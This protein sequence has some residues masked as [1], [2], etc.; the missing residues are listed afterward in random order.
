MLASGPSTRGGASGAG[1]VGAPRG[2]KA[3]PNARNG[4]STAATAAA[5]VP[6]TP[7]EEAKRKE[8]EKALEAEARKRT[9]TD[10]RII[11]LEIKAFD[12]S[13]GQIK[14]GLDADDFEEQ[15]QLLNDDEEDEEE[16]ELK[17]KRRRER[18]EEDVAVE[19]V[20]VENAEVA[21]KPE[22]TA[23]VDSFEVFDV[24]AGESVKAEEAEPKQD[25]ADAPSAEQKETVTEEEAKKEDAAVAKVDE[26]EE[27]RGA[28]R[29]AK[30]SSPEPG[31]CRDSVSSGRVRSSH[32]LAFPFLFCC[33]S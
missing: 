15:Q 9:I 20:K 23:E 12:W 21:A 2:P 18:E 19:G 24:V 10:F 30:M 22:R 33:G 6:L 17:H 8:K 26:S 27:K 14:E 16:E 1:A 3:Q 31:S 7:E 28:K 5:P 13:W 25:T 32:F 29:K 11:G 4:K